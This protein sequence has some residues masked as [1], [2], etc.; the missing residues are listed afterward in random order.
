MPDLG[1]SHGE[2]GFDDSVFLEG[3]NSW[4]ITVMSGYISHLVSQ[5]KANMKKKPPKLSAQ[6]ANPTPF[7]FPSY[8]C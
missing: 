1:G 2:F 5:N 7:P 6:C 4:F 8:A 3:P